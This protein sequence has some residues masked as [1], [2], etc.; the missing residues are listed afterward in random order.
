M[1][2]WAVDNVSGTNTTCDTYVPIGMAA[3]S[4]AAMVPLASCSCS[5]ARHSEKD[6]KKVSIK[7]R[8]VDH[9]NSLLYY[10]I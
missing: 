4:I 3:A 9:H 7:V 1:I 10:N 8:M 6:Y 2:V 5:A